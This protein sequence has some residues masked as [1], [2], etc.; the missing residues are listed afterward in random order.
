MK[1]IIL[2]KIKITQDMIGK[3]VLISSDTQIINKMKYGELQAVKFYNKL[4]Q[5]SLQQHRLLFAIFNIVVDHFKGINKNL[6]TIEKIKEQAKLNSKYVDCWYEFENKK[7]GEKQLNI[8]TKSISF[9]TLPHLEACGLFEE[10]FEFCAELLCT[11]KEDL[12]SNAE[13]QIKLRKTC[14]L[15]GKKA[16]QRH[17]L[18]SQTKSNIEKYGKKIIDADFNLIDVCHDCHASHSNPELAKYILTE[19]QFEDLILSQP[20]AKELIENIKD[21]AIKNALKIKYEFKGD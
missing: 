17:H 8:K 1:E 3:D 21:E 20:N 10:F 7:T 6:D 16:T 5:R 13:E 14:I 9:D 18:F 4:S 19:T 2:T 11:S 15:C 12:L